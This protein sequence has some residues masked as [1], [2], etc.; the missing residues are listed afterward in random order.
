MHRQDAHAQSWRRVA[1]LTL[2]IDL[3]GKLQGPARLVVG[4]HNL[5]ESHT[6]RGNCTKSPAMKLGQALSGC[7]SACTR[8]C[9]RR[10]LCRPDLSC[11]GAG[12]PV[13]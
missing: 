9:L 3:A 8:A 1:W 2:L 4:H 13:S 11:I 6:T 5:I 10:G 12:Q 7:Q